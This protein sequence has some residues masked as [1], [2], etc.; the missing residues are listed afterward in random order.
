MSTNQF[1]CHDGIEPLNNINYYDWSYAQKI[2][3]IRKQFWGIVSG[4]EPK[5]LGSL[6]HVT[7]KAWV[8]K[9]KEALASIVGNVD[10]SQYHLTCPAKSSKMAW[11]AIECHHTTSGL[12]SIV[13]MWRQLFRMKKAGDD[14]TMWEHIGII[15]STIDK[16]KSLGEE[17]SDCQVITIIMEPLP[18]SYKNLI[19][20]PDSHPDHN[21]L[22]YIISCIFNEETHQKEEHDH[23]L[24]TSSSSSASDLALLAAARQA[25]LDRCHAR[26]M[27]KGVILQNSHT[28]YV[29][30]A[31]AQ[32]AD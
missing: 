4:D 23:S 3:L 12:G 26:S 13:A 11:D 28:L 31:E 2:M 1:K 6:N 9:D 20:A 25:P 18:V 24:I 29:S 15:Q 14:M 17:C 7:V 30:K 10:K 19:I 8:R 22:D 5:P 21:K 27:S 32:R 16:L